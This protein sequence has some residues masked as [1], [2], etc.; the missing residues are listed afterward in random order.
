MGFSFS[1]RSVT[2]ILH[3]LFISCIH[4]YHIFIN[5]KLTVFSKLHSSE[6]RGLRS[7]KYSSKMLP[8]LCIR[9]KFNLCITL[10]FYLMNSLPGLC[11]YRTRH[12]L[13]INVKLSANLLFMNS[14]YIVLD[15]LFS[16]IYLRLSYMNINTSKIIPLFPPSVYVTCIPF[17]KLKTLITLNNI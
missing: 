5:S 17:S 13:V 2:Q 3:F 10:D 11:Q 15:L 16:T 1:T 9:V 8:N 4:V 14:D 7:T 12:T 6:I